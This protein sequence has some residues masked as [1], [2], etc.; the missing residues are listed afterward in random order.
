[1]LRRRRRQSDDDRCRQRR[2]L[3]L[4][5]S[6]P[7]HETRRLPPGRPAGSAGHHSCSSSPPTTL[8]T[9]TARPTRHNELCTSADVQLFQKI[10]TCPD[11]YS[12][13]ILL[14]CTLCSLCFGDCNSVQQVLVKETVHIRS[15]FQTVCRFVD[16]NFILRMLYPYRDAYY[17][18]LL[19]FML[20]VLFSCS[21]SIVIIRICLVTSCY[22]S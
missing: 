8:R 21:V 20:F 11:E 13:Q 16:R 3:T 17:L 9:S 12:Y 22:N 6:R 15:S 1:M 18:F 10:L 4:P 2:P 7:P 5:Q 14:R 19:H